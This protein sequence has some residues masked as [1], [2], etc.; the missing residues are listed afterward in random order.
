MNQQSII[1][2]NELS[3]SPTISYH[4]SEENEIEM[5]QNENDM[6]ENELNLNPN[7]II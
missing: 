6:N 2:R 3:I 7:T 4:E 1:P 5:E